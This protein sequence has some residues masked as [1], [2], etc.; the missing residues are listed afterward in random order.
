MRYV[1]DSS[2]LTGCELVDRQHGQLFDAINNLLAACESGADRDGLKKSLDFLSDYTVKHFFDEE[3]LL[4]KHGFSDIDHHHQF[5]A[6]FKEVVRD[7]SHEFIL[8]GAS[9]ALVTEVEN[10]IGGW[11]VEH[12]KGQDFRWTK[13][14]KETAPD[15]FTAAAVKT[16]VTP[17]SKVT[18]AASALPGSAA[19]SAQTTPALSSDRAVAIKLHAAPPAAASAKTGD[20]SPGKPVPPAP[21]SANA[22]ADSPNKPAPSGLRGNRRSISIQITLTVLTSLTVLVAVA[23]MAAL[24]VIHTRELF[25]QSILAGLALILVGAA[26]NFVFVKMLVIHPIRQIS[27]ALQKAGDGDISR[28]IQPRSGG[29]IGDLAGHFDRTLESLRRL[30]AIVQNEAEA[31]DDTG[32]DLSDNMNRTAASM[33]EINGGIQRMQRQIGDQADSVSAANAAVERITANI[34]RLTEEIETQSASV[35]QSSSAIEEMLANIDS[36]TRISRANSENVTRLAEASEVGRKGLEAVAADMREIA[37]ESEGLLEINAVLQNIA[38]Q[39]NLLSMNA[40]IEAAHA[41]ESGKGF[42]VVADEIR[43]LAESSG[44]QSKTISTVLKKIRDAMTKISLATAEVLDKFG[45]IDGGVKAVSDQEERI[46]SA[47]EEQSSG[48][49]Q[50]LEAIQKLNDITQTVKSGSEE[51]RQG[52]V[53]IVNQGQNLKA[54]TGEI[55]NGMNQMA[56]HAGEVN[57]SVTRANAVSGKGASGVLRE[58]VSHFVLPDKQ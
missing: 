45:A 22:G 23:V 3:Q 40:A 12:I 58:A 49:R 57:N 1:M 47:M 31:V 25:A 53:E 41:G 13:E 19:L 9:E 24:G 43:K 44:T 28:R 38:S 27:G 46:R 17:D 42:A 33:G 20:A 15:M 16:F 2:F 18:A 56:I 29:E 48:S 30:V 39:T 10:K 21:L 7:L 54:V 34:N 8:K 26:L 14:L 51:M 50:I 11:L 36:V 32:R 6:V 37:R 35:S 5:H 52:S 55:A 4:K